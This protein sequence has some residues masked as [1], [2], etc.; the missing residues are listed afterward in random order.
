MKLGDGINFSHLVSCL[1]KVVVLV[2]AL[3]MTSMSSRLIMVSHASQTLSLSFTSN[4]SA[5]GMAL[6]YKAQY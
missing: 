1:R 3:A 6:T 5:T 4:R 2:D